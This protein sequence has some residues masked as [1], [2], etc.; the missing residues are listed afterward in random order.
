LVEL[1]TSDRIA[2]ARACATFYKAPYSPR[3]APGE[4]PP[5]VRLEV[6]AKMLAALAARAPDKLEVFRDVLRA[7]EAGGADVSA[8]ASAAA[9]GGGQADPRRYARLLAESAPVGNG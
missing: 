4:Q 2:C 7:I 6:D 8:L 5:V 9:P 3:A 1:S